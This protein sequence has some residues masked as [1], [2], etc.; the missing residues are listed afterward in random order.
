LDSE[1]V[2]GLLAKVR[3]TD[4]EL[5]A[6]EQFGKLLFDRAIGKNQAV[7][8]RWT[9]TRAA[10]GAAG[11][12]VRFRLRL[13]APEIAELPWELL[14]DDDF[15]APSADVVLE[16][17]LPGTEPSP[18]VTTTKA[19]VLLIVQRP[20]K[21]PIAQEV[22]DGIERI[23]SETTG[24]EKPRVL[25]NASVADINSELW[26]GYH[27]VH[28]MGHGDPDRVIFADANVPEGVEKTAAAFAAL[29]TGQRQV[30]LVVLNVCASGQT[31]GSG[32]FTGFGPLLT[33]KRIPAVVGMQYE[34]VKQAT[35][36]RF[37][38][39]FY[40][41]LSKSFPV[42]LAVNAARQALRAHAEAKRD[43][44]TP[45]LY[46]A[47]R[48]GRILEFV[49]DEQTAEAR[50]VKLALEE[51]EGMQAAYEELINLVEADRKRV[52]EIDS[53]LTFRQQLLE[54]RER[55]AT[56]LGVLGSAGPLPTFAVSGWKSIAHDA[57][58]QLES[59]A[60]KAEAEDSGWWKKT[61]DNAVA[62]A[63]DLSDSNFGKVQTER[64]VL[65]EAI[66]S[67]LVWLDDAVSMRIEQ[68][69]SSS[70]NA[71]ARLKPR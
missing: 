34:K 53:L 27:V 60:K 56:V 30:R 24:F 32:L 69:K 5:A 16:R 28:Y 29:F 41:A 38:D 31:P 7:H 63:A 4:D 9:Q 26:N 37:N 6:R 57:L 52:A 44:S 40:R 23:L 11:G 39:S 49:P 43:W 50:R 61:H 12:R 64:D 21:R 13:E 45:V 18:L 2:K 19:R 71:L 65:D 22:I 36:A 25:V 68:A 8:T 17:Y 3:S 51:A 58:P 62:V 70:D 15:I 1:S 67:G 59:C 14:Y 47:T 10:A 46:M 35:A 55:A 54:F 48:T 66:G 42:D 33:S 20:E